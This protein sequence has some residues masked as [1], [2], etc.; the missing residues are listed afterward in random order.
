[1]CFATR[2]AQR[3]HQRDA[4]LRLESRYVA[5]S[6]MAFRSCFGSTTGALASGASPQGAAAGEPMRAAATRLSA[7]DCLRVRATDEER[8]G[9]GVATCRRYGRRTTTTRTGGGGQQPAA[10]AQRRRC[11][12]AGFQA[13]SV[14]T[15]RAPCCATKSRTQKVRVC[16]TS[17]IAPRARRLGN[18]GSAASGACRRHRRLR[19][20]QQCQVRAH[21]SA[22]AAAARLPGPAAALAGTPAAVEACHASGAARTRC[23]WAAAT[24]GAC[25][26]WANRVCRSSCTAP[27]RHR[28]ARHHCRRRRRGLMNAEP[29][30]P[31][32]RPPR[33]HATAAMAAR[34]A[35]PPRRTR[36]RLHRLRP[37]AVLVA[38]AATAGAQTATPPLA[39]AADARAQAA[40]VHLHPAAES[41]A[42]AAHLARQH[43]PRS[44][45][46]CRLALQRVPS[47]LPSAPSA[48]Q[49]PLRLRPHHAPPRRRPRAEAPWGCSAAAAT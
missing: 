21:A 13:E 42:V 31:Q 41:Q 15:V 36:R 9:R 18:G 11:V 1:M 12:A 46:G 40:G 43:P 39:P 23:R 14:V 22:R 28:D 27:D 20:R 2:D 10:A 48:P 45:R 8:E 7:C 29:A 44:L 26:T 3:A 47:A 32:P 25:A 16:H 17:L 30:S 19:R 37:S 34:P 4:H 38:A 5:R 49:P 33:R 6:L 24:G 35:A